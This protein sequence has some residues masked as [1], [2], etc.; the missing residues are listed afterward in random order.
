ME[1]NFQLMHRSTEILISG[2]SE[3]E[4][5]GIRGKSDG[6]GG[7][8]IHCIILPGWVGLEHLVGRYSGP[9]SQ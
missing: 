6:W 7:S 3:I 9:F 8:I 1:R 4:T 2:W 5:R